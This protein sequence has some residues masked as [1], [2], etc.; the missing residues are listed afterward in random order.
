M[1]PLARLQV[2]S[3]PDAQRFFNQAYA[4]VAGARNITIVGGGS[5]G[6]ELA[7]EIRAGSL[8]FGA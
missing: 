5:V 6:V 2:D 7:G 8:V 1:N 3:V 4:A